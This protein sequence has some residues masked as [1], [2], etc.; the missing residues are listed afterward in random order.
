MRISES[1]QPK[2][3]VDK[4]Y[5][6]AFLAILLAVCIWPTKSEAAVSTG[7]NAPIMQNVREVSNVSQFTNA[8]NA[9][10]ALSP[11]GAR[12]TI[13][14]APG[15][16]AMAVG[17]YRLHVSN[18][19]CIRGSG[20]HQTTITGIGAADLPMIELFDNCQLEDVKLS[21][22]GTGANPQ[23]GFKASLG[24][25]TS[26]NVSI[27][28]V[29]MSGDDDN[30][31]LSL[32]GS[33]WDSALGFVGLEW[34]ADECI[35]ENHFDSIYM[36]GTA[37][38][39]I[40]DAFNADGPC[41]LRVYNSRLASQGPSLNSTSQ[42]RGDVSNVRMLGLSARVE[43]YDCFLYSAG[44]T[45]MTSAAFLGSGPSGSDLLSRWPGG[46][47]LNNC[48][49]DIIASNMVSGGVGGN[50]IQ[51]TNGWVFLSG[52]SSKYISYYN[53]TATAANERITWASH[54]LPLHEPVVF[55]GSE[56]PG[57]ITFGA[58]YYVNTIV[59]A[60]NFTVSATLG[61]SSVNISS[62][63]TA[64]QC[65]ANGLDQGRIYGNGTNFW[66]QSRPIESG[67]ITRS[68]AADT[69]ETNLMGEMLW[70][71]TLGATGQSIDI[72]AWGTYGASANTK[73]IRLKFGN[74]TNNTVNNDI[75]ILDTAGRAINGGS[76]FLRGSVT[77]VDPSTVRAS[78]LFEAPAFTTNV[79][80][81]VS[82]T[83]STN[84]FLRL[85]GSNHSAAAAD[86]VLTGYKITHTP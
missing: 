61:G 8:V 76:W 42:A 32:S 47:Y 31:W 78:L 40:T 85:T 60:N 63:G 75:T 83:L 55:T 28:R 54:G 48:Q 11:D 70:G 23:L 86:I 53:V 79:Y 13:L 67:V 84:A 35:F 62:A 58:T 2:H 80:T 9:Y 18:N 41:I 16:Y 6:A 56:A 26:T 33:Y 7:P 68:T 72:H 19:I 5:W 21:S 50:L 73:A 65:A 17:T 69:T 15:T 38:G 37:N 45:N 22:S 10:N 57:G 77:R 74:Y 4:Y 14:L 39:V 49:F 71:N 36:E 29:W 82:L 44:G 34:R 64:V 1:D 59:D 43:L 66:K 12:R 30:L 27:K 51:N 24:G 81:S 20:M 25:P 52:V 3:S 46:L